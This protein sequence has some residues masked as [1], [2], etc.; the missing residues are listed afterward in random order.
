MRA[1]LPINEPGRLRALHSYHLLDSQPEP[2]FD[3]I[4][5]LACYLL[6]A[7]IALVSLLD[8]DRQW[9]KSRVGIPYKEMPRDEAI[10]AYTILSP[11]ALIIPNALSDTRFAR[12]PS[13]E[14]YPWI[15]FYAGIALRTAEGYALGTLCVLDTRPR[16]DFDTHQRE[17]LAML[18]QETMAH[19][20]LRRSSRLL[21]EA[22]LARRQSDLIGVLCCRLASSISMAPDVTQALT[23]TL[24]EL[25]NQVG[26]GKGSAWMK[27]G[28]GGGYL[29]VC[30]GRR[31]GYAGHFGT[32]RTGEN[33]ATYRVSDALIRRA[34]DEGRTLMEYDPHQ[35][36]GEA[37]F[38]LASEDGIN[39]LFAFLTDEPEAQAR[40]MLEQTTKVIARVAPELARKR[41]N[42]Q[43]RLQE[44]ELTRA[45]QMKDHFLAMLAHELRNPLAPIL[46]AVELLKT[47]DSGDALEVIERQVHHMSRLMEDLLDISRV[48]SGK[49]TLHKKTIDLAKTVQ[50]ATRT[51]YDVFASR[52]QPFEVILPAVPLWVEADPARIEQIVGNLLHNAAK[53]SGRGLPVTLV[54]ECEG[55]EA[56]LCVRDKGVGIPQESLEKIFEPFVQVDGSRAMA[57]G[58][59]GL[60][61][62]LVRQMVVLHG[63]RVSVKSAGIGSGSEFCVHL[64]L[65]EPPPVLDQEPDRFAEKIGG[66]ASC[67]V[68]VVE[69]HDDLAGTLHR[70]LTHWGHTVERVSRGSQ[71]LQRAIAMQPDVVLIDIGL[72][73]LDGYTVARQL[74]AS[75]ALPK[76]IRL[77]AITGYGQEA[78]RLAA[79]EAG[80]DVYL[81]K[82]V[83]PMQLR[84]WV[85][86]KSG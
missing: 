4:T 12:Y 37:A 82:P 3:Q 86:R 41:L 80:F 65:I 58:G 84:E 15:R 8:N 55:K 51:V 40:L 36:L 17:I 33:G 10:C 61:L 31:S 79:L 70:L 85:R 74:S 20:D 78:D 52:G 56:R 6:D 2:S 26:W 32:S 72:P 83:D 67:R 54:L 29:L 43:L 11:D 42:E 48:T 62:A 57:K 22:L 44:V 13:V 81:L 60:G 21:S 18:A 28:E 19:A 73:D 69:D 77:I 1:P 14:S 63:G 27:S 39:V 49:M 53:Y 59:L 5:A 30:Q 50:E 24:E 66:V 34:W 23:A 9:F 35:P 64:P 25:C 68:L 16:D 7:P 45:N 38:P 47:S 76:R 46:N 71:A 75:Q